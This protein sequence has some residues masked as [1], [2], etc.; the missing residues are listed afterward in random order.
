MLAVSA[1]VST[2]SHIQQL[3]RI[4]CILSNVSRRN[5][6]AIF[7]VFECHAMCLCL[8]GDNNDHRLYVVDVNVEADMLSVLLSLVLPSSYHHLLLAG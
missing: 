6:L 2:H 7:C 8:R 1:F 3:L 4:G 5:V